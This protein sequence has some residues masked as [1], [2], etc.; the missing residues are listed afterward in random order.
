M[1]CGRSPSCNAWHM[2]SRGAL[3]P[4]RTIARAAVRTLAAGKVK[5]KTVKV[6]A[7]ED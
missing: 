1:E 3:R 4:S 5:G 2:A 6:R 7:L